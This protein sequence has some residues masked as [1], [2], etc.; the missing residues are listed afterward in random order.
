[1]TELHRFYHDMGISGVTWDKNV[2]LVL[3]SLAALTVII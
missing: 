1:M 2:N 3:I